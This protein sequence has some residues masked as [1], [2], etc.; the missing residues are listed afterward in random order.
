LRDIVQAEATGKYTEKTVDN[1]DLETKTLVEEELGAGAKT[2]RD[3]KLLVTGK[4]PCNC[5]SRANYWKFL[6]LTVSEIC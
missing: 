5:P 3:G 2:I 4:L 1:I 6:L